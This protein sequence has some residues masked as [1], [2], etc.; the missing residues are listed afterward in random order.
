MC[1]NC[2]YCYFFI[3]TFFVRAPLSEVS[4]SSIK[5]L[6]YRILRLTL[7]F[8]RFW[9]IKFSCLHQDVFQLSILFFSD[10]DFCCLLSRRWSSVRCPVRLC[11]AISQWICI[12]SLE[13]VSMKLPDIHLHAVRDTSSSS[14]YV[15]VVKIRKVSSTTLW[16]YFSVDLHRIFGN[17]VYEAARYASSCWP[18]YTFEFHI[19]LGGEAP[20][21]VQ[22][23]FVK[24][25]I[26]GF[27]S[28]LW[29]LCPQASQIS[30]N[31]RKSVFFSFIFWCLEI[32]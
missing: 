8:R 5:S 10:F 23:D 22:Y 15:L 30:V 7:F 16:N 9:Q 29:Q 24:L 1:Y 6:Y 26:S 4:Q 25:F 20:Q 19:C 17:C 13:I 11:E 14:T 12:A 2:Q 28:H 31:R 18:G 27:A 21:G 3:P 32:H